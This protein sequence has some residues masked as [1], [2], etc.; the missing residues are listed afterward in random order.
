M[1]R[2]L[3]WLIVWVLLAGAGARAE[4]VIAPSDSADSK[5]GYVDYWP[6]SLKGESGGEP[7]EQKGGT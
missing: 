6:D 2:G 5:D 4:I 7:I 1:A 3:F